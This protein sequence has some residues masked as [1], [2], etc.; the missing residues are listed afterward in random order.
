MSE[1]DHSTIVA[2]GVYGGGFIRSI[3]PATIF[4]RLKSLGIEMRAGRP[5][6]RILC[7]N[8]GMEFPSQAAAAQHYGVYREN[9]RKVLKGI[10]THT[11]GKQFKEITTCEP[12][13][14]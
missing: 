3:T 7:V 14:Q 12:V 5:K 11:G 6:K 8:D 10:Y 9:I 13:N 1:E 2:M 4:N